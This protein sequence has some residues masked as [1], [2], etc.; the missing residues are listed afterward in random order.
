[1]AATH[2]PTAISIAAS[3]PKTAPTAVLESALEYVDDIEPEEFD[4]LAEEYARRSHTEYHAYAEY[5]GY[6][7]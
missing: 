3:D 2:I 7:Y 4:M 5:G 1:M 6:D